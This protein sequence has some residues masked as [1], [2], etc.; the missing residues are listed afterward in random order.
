MFTGIIVVFGSEVPFGDDDENRGASEPNE[1]IS[2]RVYR[3]SIYGQ[4]SED[5]GRS[6][7]EWSSTNKTGNAEEQGNYFEGD[8]L[9]PKMMLRNGL[10]AESF[11]WPGGVVPVEIENTFG[12]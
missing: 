12:N 2:L 4:P 6:L 5:V 3:S 8:I 9:F 1:S 7:R 11:R 10:K